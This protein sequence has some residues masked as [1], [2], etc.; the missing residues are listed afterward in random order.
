MLKSAFYERL[1]MEN[2][3]KLKAIPP[4]DR[5]GIQESREIIQEDS[6]LPRSESTRQTIVKLSED[7]I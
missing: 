2:L 5:Y 6:Q 4:D 3:A 7:Y 1:S